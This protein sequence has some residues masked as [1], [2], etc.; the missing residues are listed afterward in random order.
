MLNFRETLMQGKTS[1]EAGAGSGVKSRTINSFKP[2]AKN[3]TALQNL[4]GSIKGMFCD[5]NEQ[6]SN[7]YRLYLRR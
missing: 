6:N 2:Q 7:R 3:R 5:D 1:C 4:G